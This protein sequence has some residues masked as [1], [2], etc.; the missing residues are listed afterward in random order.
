MNVLLLYYRTIILKRYNNLFNSITSFENLCLALRKAQSGKKNKD[1]VSKFIYIQEI[2][3]LKLQNE[4]LQ[5]RYNP[6]KYTTF[7]IYDK[8]K[9]LIS[10]APFRDRIVHHALCNV[11]EP[12]FE[13]SFIHDTYAN[14]TGKG[15]HKAIKRCAEYSRVNKYVL[16]FDIKKYFASIDHEILKTIICSKIKDKDTLWIINLIIDNSN[17]QEEISDYFFDDHLFTPIERKKGLPIGNQTSQLFANIYLD[18]LDHYI[19]EKLR[20]QFYIRYVDDCLLFADN[21][22]ELWKIG[23]KIIHELEFFRLKIHPTKYH[24]IPVQCGIPFLGYRIFSEY[25][26]LDKNNIHRFKR[27]MRFFQNAYA[28]KEIDLVTIKQ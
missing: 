17:K 27:R 6:G 3:L 16:K 2:E 14:R 21:K 18:P 5:K 10:A 25:Y 19:K 9:R 11:I 12:I 20:C 1:I 4:I 15:T 13:K 8:K 28:N 24:I 23:E 26:F 22:E 7:Y